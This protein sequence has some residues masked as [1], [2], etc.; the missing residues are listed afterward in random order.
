MADDWLH[1]AS[2]SCVVSPGAEV[3]LDWM[4]TVRAG[5][6]YDVN[7]RPNVIS[8]PVLYWSKVEPWLQVVGCHGGIV[9]ASD[10][11]ISFPPNG[12]SANDPLAVATD[13]VR[14]YGLSLAV[15]TL[16]SYGAVEIEANGKQTR[17]PGAPTEVVDTVGAGDTFMASLLDSR[18]NRALPPGGVVEPGGAAASIVCSRRGQT[19]RRPPRWMTWW[20]EPGSADPGAWRSCEA[21]LGR[22]G[23]VA[24]AVV[25]VSSPGP[26]DHRQASIRDPTSPAS[27]WGLHRARQCRGQER[28]QIVQA[29][30][31]QVVDAQLSTG[32]QHRACSLIAAAGSAQCARSTWRRQHR[33]R[34]RETG[35]DSA[36]TVWNSIRSSSPAA[37]TWG[38]LRRTMSSDGS[39]PDESKVGTSPRKVHQ[40][41]PRTGSHIENCGTR[42]KRRQQ[43]IRDDPV[44][45]AEGTQRES[46][47]S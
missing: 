14:I 37:R 45:P 40:K 11:E 10:E 4:R 38:R 8:D 39:T 12:R 28:S 9:R 15:I 20:P 35:N 34:R 22:P 16:A 29:L 43:L 21:D 1:I 6:S 31:P 3:L 17:V 2:L 36:A 5:V 24:A 25:A 13:W 33:M 41:P 44:E 23:L 30:A 18:I 7:V 47:R 42:G 32:T 46:N 19:H 26:L 27:L